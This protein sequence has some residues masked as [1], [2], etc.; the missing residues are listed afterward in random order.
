MPLHAADLDIEA[1]AVSKHYR[2]GRRRRADGFW[3]LRDVSFEV[4]RGETFGIVGRNGAGKSTLLK[5]LSGITAPTEG[6]IVI[7][8]RAAALIEVGSGFHPELTGRE[9]I[10]LSGAIL[11]MT[12]REI[13][14]K[15]PRIVDFAGV[16][17]FIDTPVKWYSSGMYVRLGFAIAAHLEPD[18]L[19]VD[20]V[21]AVGDAEFQRR[22]LDRIL[23]LVRQ[24]T[25][26]VFVSH[27]LTAV[28][29]L[30]RRAMLIEGGR[31][32]AIG[33]P[34]EV[35]AAYHRLLAGD[36]PAAPEHAGTI[37]LAGLIWQPLRGGMS[38]ATGEPL[39][40]ELRY[41]APAP[42]ARLVFEV[43]Y[44]TADGRLPLAQARTDAAGVSVPAGAGV[45]EF[46]CPSL[47]LAP[48]LYY[49]GATVREAGTLRVLSWWDGGTM[50]DVQG[51]ADSA[52]PLSMPHQWRLVSPA[53]AR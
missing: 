25:T 2:L 4:A 51:T 26:I 24:G 39:R 45:V 18:V 28:E 3:A 41:L 31:V 36:V 17:P 6:R 35:V 48:G 8:G 13:A 5:L 10:F 42:L 32:A 33:S 49:V 34:A 16:A 14:A 12:R 53:L 9:N 7:R 29:R 27:D 43:T 21:L 44:Y 37:E 23:E 52:G 19:L 20:E 38:V 46:V 11:G 22:C 40:L 50:L 1:T 47:A 15:L 30:C